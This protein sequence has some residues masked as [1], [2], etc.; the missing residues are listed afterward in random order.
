MNPD[1]LAE[2]EEERGFLLRSIRDIE[3]EHAA[4]DVDD[5]DFR[6]LRDGYVA[7]A[8]AVLREIDNG[9][10]SLMAKQERPLWRRVAIIGGTLVVAVALGVF[11]AD[12]AGQRL[13]GQSLESRAGVAPEA[14]ATG[15]RITFGVATALLVVALSIAASAQRH[16]FRNRAVAP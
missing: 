10:S 13:P 14:V 4:G 3:A 15:M 7:R 1:R 12:S 9:R 5:A 6:T 8:S 11:V 2:L 16:A